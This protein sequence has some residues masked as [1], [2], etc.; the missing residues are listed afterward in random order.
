MLSDI[1]REQRIM[2]SFAKRKK[3]QYILAIPAVLVVAALL[4]MRVNDSFTLGS[5]S[6]DT[7][8]IAGLV[9]IV[10]ILVISFINWRCPACNSYFG[11]DISPKHCPK[12]GV[13]LTRS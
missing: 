3:I 8:S 12:C 1:D 13:K 5:L 9:I 6:R 10:A 4:I 7:V 2:V 11:R